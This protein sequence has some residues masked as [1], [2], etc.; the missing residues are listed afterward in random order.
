MYADRVSITSYGG[1]VQGLDIKEFFEGRSMPRNRELMRIFK[2][3]DMVEQLGSGMS[4]ILSVYDTTVFKV[5]Q[6][7]LEV[8]FPFTDGYAESLSSQKSSEKSSEKIISLIAEEPQITA[9]QLAKQIGL[10]SRA[11][12]KHLKKLK[13]SGKIERVGGRK[14]GY[15]HII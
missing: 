9:I 15:W 7:F 12:E 13:E 3:L 6:N 1:L 8:C 5:S 10:T 14:E 11:V 2:D 4:R